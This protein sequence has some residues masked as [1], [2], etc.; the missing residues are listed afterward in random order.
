MEKCLAIPSARPARFHSSWLT[1]GGQ[2]LVEQ[3]ADDLGADATHRVAKIVGAHE[4]G[5]L[6]VDDLALVVGHVVEGQQLLAH[7]EVVGFDLAL[8]LLDLAREHAA[9]DDL[10]FLHAGHGQPLLRAIRIAEDAHQVVFH[11]QVE[12]ARARV[13]L[14][15]RTAAQLVVD[16]AGL[17]A[18]GADDV[19]AAGGH[20]LVVTLLPLGFEARERDFVERRFA[21]GFL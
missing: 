12:A 13:T 19:Q 20:H 7:V 17:V 1:F 4:F 9:F 10:A 3:P 8:R 11:R 2:V 15:A 16:A 21:R 6:L 18:L 5:A 14:A